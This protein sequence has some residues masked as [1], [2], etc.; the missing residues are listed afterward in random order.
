M[1][2]SNWVIYNLYEPFDMRNS[3]FNIKRS[4]YFNSGANFG[5]PVVFTAV[6]PLPAGEVNIA[7]TLYVLAPYTTKWNNYNPQ[8]FGSNEYADYKDIIMMRLGETYLLL[9]EAQLAQ[10]N[11]AGAAASLNV[12]RA[13]A[14]ASLIQANQVTLDFILDERARELL[15]EENR[16]MTLV[17]TGTLVTRTL[18][19]NSSYQG[20]GAGIT[21][22]NL[23]LPIPQSEINLNLGATLTQ[24]PGY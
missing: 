18:R 6:K 23:L 21:N 16:R 14:G 19:L 3:R 4:F 17:R 10:G 9:A 7:D 5:K 22:T 12:I 13:R 1:R 20:Q 24:N 11:T 8:D 2:L 15:A